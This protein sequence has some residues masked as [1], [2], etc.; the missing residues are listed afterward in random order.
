MDQK[1]QFTKIRFVAIEEHSLNAFETS[2][3]AYLNEGYK[4]VSTS[5]GHVNQL[6]TNGELYDWFHAVMEHPGEP[7]AAVKSDEDGG[8]ATFTLGVFVGAA[9]TISAFLIM[10]YPF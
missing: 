10:S 3:N 1:Q 2:V 8:L 5:S 9:A 4:I 7:A 6:S